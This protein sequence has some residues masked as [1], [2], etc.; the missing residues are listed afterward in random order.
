MLLLIL[1]FL[2]AVGVS[3]LCSILEAVFLSITPSFVASRKEQGAW[4][5]HKLDKL[6]REP[7]Q[8]L[9]AILSLNT[10]A[11]TVGAAGVGAQ[12]QIVF[13]N[14]P[15]SI[16]SSVLTLLIL[17][18]SEIIPK[19]LGALFWRALALPSTATILVLTLML[20]P[21]VKLSSLIS[22][23]LAPKTAVPSIS[24]EEVS[25]MADIG[26]NEGVFDKSELKALKNLVGFRRQTVKS[27]LTPR[28]VT[29]VF[30]GHWTVS[31]VMETYKEIPFSRIPL[32]GEQSDEILGY[33]M[34]SDILQ[35]AARDQH[36]LPVSKLARKVTVVP[37]AVPIWS[38]FQRFLRSRE[39][40][41][42]VV[43]E[44]GNFAGVVTLEDLMETMIGHEIMDEHDSV[45]DLR[46]WAA[47]RGG[48][49]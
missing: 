21:F 40:L 48:K 4:I 12:A 47:F 46:A 6:K 14:L 11:H 22:R 8:P 26:F 38:L 44:Y 27:I 10:I 49:T 36:D 9:A 7:D 18:F 28:V 39:H 43:D 33:V 37:E 1:Y 3:F 19:T 32:I 20:W 23:L 17:V 42:V 16:I 35:A 34:K 5:D 31:D 25:S 29:T 15:F 45:E 24:R 13:E 30:P 41:A 2:L